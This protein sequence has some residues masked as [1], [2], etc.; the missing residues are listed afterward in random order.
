MKDKEYIRPIALF[1]AEPDRD[2][3]S[4]TVDRIKEYLIKEKKIRED[5]VAI[6]I[7]G[8]DDLK[9]NNLFAKN[10]KIRY[11]IT[12]SALA[13]GW[14]C[15]FAYVLVSVSN[16]E[17]KVAVEQ[18]IGRIMRMPFAQ[19]RINENLNKSYVFASA[20]NFSGGCRPDYK[21]VRRKWL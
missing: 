20:K 15:S 12:I 21:G 2:S 10:C 16:L 19:K 18:I 3:N 9:N 5:E 6:K 7:S 11:I 17:S 1:Q 13:E 4:I 8:R 14:D